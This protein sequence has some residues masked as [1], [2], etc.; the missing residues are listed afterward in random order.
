MPS[1]LIFPSIVDF[2]HRLKSKDA[3][4]GKVGKLTDA[5][6]YVLIP[7]ESKNGFPKLKSSKSVF[8]P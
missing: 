8:I 1:E 4:R 6:R 7:E 2:F 5:F 3:K